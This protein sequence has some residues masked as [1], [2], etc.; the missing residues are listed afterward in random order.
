MRR[1]LLILGVLLAACTILEPRPDPSRFFTL[2]AVAQSPDGAAPSGLTV[3]LGPVRLP[4]YLD[5]PELA[6]RIASSEV[7]F[8]SNDRWAEPLSASLRRVL[9]QNLATLLGTNEIVGF[10]WPVGTPVDWGV[11]VDVVRFERTTNGE[12]EVSARWTVR[13]NGTGR[14]RI[15]RE[16]RY[17]QKASA[18]G[19]PATV[20]AWNEAIAAL[21][22]DIAAAIGSLGPP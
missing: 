14:S 16:T 5:R 22:G 19:T 13:E 18:S 7:S 11:A 8:S 9:A 20:D 3:G 1:A 12:V 6:T 10:P 15:A 4:A 2:S 17:T 21:S